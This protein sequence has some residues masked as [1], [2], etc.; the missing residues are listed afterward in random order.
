[1]LF[2][3]IVELEGD[4]AKTI[5][6]FGFITTN[7]LSKIKRK[8]M[9]YLIIEIKNNTYTEP[10]TGFWSIDY[11]ILFPDFSK[12]CFHFLLIITNSK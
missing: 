11:E 7:R 12:I 2:T 4:C 9:F 3:Q 10:T 6:T 5:T 1:M 8:Q